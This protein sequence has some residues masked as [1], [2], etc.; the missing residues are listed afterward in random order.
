MLLIAI[1]ALQ[2]S[3]ILIGLLLSSTCFAFAGKIALTFDDAP[4]ADSPLLSGEERTNKII[5]TLK[6][7]KVPDALFFVKADNLNPATINRI[8]R[9]SDAGMHIANHSFSHQSANTLPADDFLVDAFRAHLLL[10]DLSNFLPYFRP[11]YLHY[12]KDVDTIAY[13]QK[14]LAA[15]NYQDGFVTIDNADWAINALLVKAASEGKKIDLKKARRLYVQVL[16]QAIE[17]FDTLAQKTYGHS[18]SHILLLH[19]N[20]TTALFLGD[21]IDQIR[22]GGGHIISPQDAY[23][24]PAYQQFPMS[25]FQ[26]QGRVAATAQ[27]QGVPIDQLKH[28]AEDSQYLEAL[29]NRHAVFK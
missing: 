28:P 14:N 20:D 4:T 26:K 16:M 22:K 12:G 11:P 24:D 10:K 21:L 15:L 9:Y 8:K 27:L 6:A 1:R 19:E 13:I 23:A 29:F 18:P 3:L 7:K 2:T 17:F 5:A 25:Y